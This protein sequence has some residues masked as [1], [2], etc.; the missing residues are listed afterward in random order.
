MYSR[1]GKRVMDL[2]LAL[3][4]MIVLSPAI[5]I[6]ALSIVV[7]MGQ[8]VLF[9]QR[10][11]GLGGQPYTLFKF[12]TMREDRDEHGRPLS[13]Q[14]RLTS[15]GRL[16]RNTSCDELPELLN[17][18]A[19]QMS[20]VGPRPLL[21]QYLDRYSIEQQRRHEVRPGISGWAQVNGRNAISWPE[22]F[23]LDVWYVDHVS[24]RLD[25]RILLMTVHR[26]LRRHGIHAEGE[27]TMP[28][29]RGN[30]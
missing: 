1:F 6:I 9:R 12:R 24:F 7:T 19:G 5:L 23:K 3:A 14:E 16:L 8:P 15:L 18:I 2:T 4:L 17:V 20:L 29:F 26:V 22:R 13:D 28:E 27:A 30:Y 10:R 11:P 25:L 21:I